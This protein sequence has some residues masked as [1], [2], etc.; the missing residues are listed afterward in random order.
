MLTTASCSRAAKQG[1]K[2]ERDPEGPV[3]VDPL[4]LLEAIASELFE[5]SRIEDGSIVDQDV[6]PTPARPD[7]RRQLRNGLPGRDIDRKAKAVRAVR[8]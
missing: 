3:L 7:R 8:G 1:Q 5:W 2:P 4:H 6:E